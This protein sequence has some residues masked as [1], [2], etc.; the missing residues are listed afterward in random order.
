MGKK[1]TNN[2]NV[3]IRLNKDVLSYLKEV[4]SDYDITVN[5][6]ISELVCQEVALRKAADR[7]YDKFVKDVKKAD[8]SCLKNIEKSNG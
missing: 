2:V 3:L 6:F 8:E 1:K 4:A 7:S 5:K